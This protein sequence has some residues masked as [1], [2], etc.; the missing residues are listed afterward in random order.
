MIRS[1]NH[2]KQILQLEHPMNL[3]QLRAMAAIADTGSFSA[4]GQRLG[5]THSAIS[6]QVRHLEQEL[7]V[8]L[9]DRSF[10]PPTLTNLGRALVDRARMIQALTEEIRHLG[11]EDGLVGSLT[12]GAVPSAMLGRL[13][14]AL[15]AL[16][17]AHP[18]LRCEIHVALSG[19]LSEE[20]R[21]G[22]IDAAIALG[23]FTTIATDTDAFAQDATGERPYAHPYFWSNATLSGAPWL[24]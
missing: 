11:Q 24:D 22:R 16:R 1:D 21:S 7:G 15:G 19:E 10:K 17:R 8:A 14:H 23:D 9:V 2:C 6:Q 20:L 3:Q 4:A 12:L 18:G 5:L 13:P